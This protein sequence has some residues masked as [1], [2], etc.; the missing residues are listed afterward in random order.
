MGGSD[1]PG[2]IDDEPEERCGG[3]GPDEHAPAIV[4]GEN[5]VSADV[6]EG[7]GE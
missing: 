1:F 2:R 4:A 7:E 6:V 3:E 5:A